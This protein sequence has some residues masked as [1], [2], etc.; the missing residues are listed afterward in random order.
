[1]ALQMKPAPEALKALVEGTFVLSMGPLFERGGGAAIGM[2]PRWHSSLIGSPSANTNR[3]NDPKLDQLLDAALSS[4][5]QEKAFEII[6]EAQ[7]LMI[8]QAY[9]VPLT[10]HPQTWAIS[11]RIKGVQTNNYG[12]YPNFNSAYVEGGK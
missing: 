5:D 7:K 4:L 1:V 12:A 9:V 8:E 11:N 2:M 6:G 10:T 3:I